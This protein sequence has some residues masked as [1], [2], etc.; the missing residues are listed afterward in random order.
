M[1]KVLKLIFMFIGLLPLLASCS[2]RRVVSGSGDII[3]SEFL[4]QSEI[5]SI[6]ISNIRMVKGSYIVPIDVEIKSGEKNISF[7]GQKK[8]LDDLSIQVS[9]NTLIIS[10]DSN[11][12]YITDSLKVL[13]TGYPLSSLDFE[14]SNVT[15]DSLSLNQNPSINL[16]YASILTMDSFEGK[17]F[18]ASLGSN[19]TLNANKISLSSSIYLS[20]KEES[21]VDIKSLE[22]QDARF[23][24]NGSSIATIYSKGILNSIFTMNDGCILNISGKTTAVDLVMT[25]AKYYGKQC[26]SDEMAINIGYGKSEVET[27]TINSISV[28]SV[29]GDCKVTYFGYNPV[30]TKTNISGDLEIINGDEG[31]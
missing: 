29:I 4:P 16:D 7:V 30:I 8:I 19:S 21:N 13:V 25:N 3:T 10:G 11:T 12:N 1:K 2:Q 26:L 31:Q 27:S 17:S 24:L 28:N 22:S 14:L 18:T 9:F 6:R 5:D 23:T 20:L 15:I